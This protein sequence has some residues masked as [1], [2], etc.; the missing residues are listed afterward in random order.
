MPE[1]DGFEVCR[2]LKEDETTRDIP[3]IFITSARD[4]GE[5]MEGLRLGAVD[6][7]NKLFRP[8]E[9]LAR[10]R[11]H[12]ELGRLRANLEALVAE[13]TAELRT[14]NNR[15]QEELAQ[16]RLIE[17]AL[18]ESEE[19]F[20]NL[21]DTAP[22]A[23]WVTD[24]DRLGSFFNKSALT[25]TGRTIE[26]LLGNRWIEL[27][28][29][30]ER[31]SVCSLYHSAVLSRRPFRMEC[32][33]RRADG[34]YRWVLNTGIPRFVDHVYVGHIGTVVDTTDLKLS[35]EQMLATQ[36]L[37]SL[38]ALAAGIA[39]DFN[40]M[41]GAIFAESDVALLETTP[42]SPGRQNIERI[43]LVAVRASEIVKLLIAYAGGTSVA[44]EEL[45]LSRIVEEM[46]H[47]LDGSI[48]EK[49]VLR[50]TLAKDLLVRANAAQIQQ[51]VLNLV[52]NAAE[53]LEGREGLI[54]IATER[55]YVGRPPASEGPTGLP[56]GEYVRLVVS[57]TGC[58]MNQEVQ[59]R[60]LD[61]FYTTKFLG[62]GLGLAVVQGILRSHSGHIQIL[63]KPGTGSTFQILLPYA[64][65]V[66]EETKAS[67]KRVTP[68]P[69]TSLLAQTYT[70]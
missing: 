33:M 3:L 38:G 10:V 1:M 62:R 54:A 9:L 64:G 48:S 57:D 19:R 29:P 16:R 24:P 63:S 17:Q 22:V 36:K 43:K 59:S 60:A 50:T 26:R 44:M 40:N 13:R 67:R 49:A 69:F 30:D 37:E 5:R 42:D 58:G 4:V 35:H 14:A 55:V 39:H 32:R 31:D 51:V 66:S 56:E 2:R 65:A 7:V 47:L 68:S 23:I 6:F 28:H 25:F 46:V 18:R 8:E 45:D 41:L 52:K 53:A 61:P 11:T 21:A 27:V 12:L 20:R 15:L 34:Q 70:R